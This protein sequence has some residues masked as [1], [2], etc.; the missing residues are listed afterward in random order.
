[1][2]AR[3]NSKIPI[4]A[5]L[6]RLNSNLCCCTA[7]LPV[8]QDCLNSLF[9]AIQV[10]PDTRLHLFT[11]LRTT[12]RARQFR[13]F[14]EQGD[15]APPLLM[16]ECGS[17]A[18]HRARRNIAMSSALGSHNRAV[19]DFAVTCHSHLAGQD[20]VVSDLGRTGKTDLSAQH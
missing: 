8:F 17:P 5:M 4:A 6:N 13:K 14:G 7:S 1:M 10:F 12:N 2:R 19:A 15:T 11:P 18:D 16:V 9:G 20:H 3:T